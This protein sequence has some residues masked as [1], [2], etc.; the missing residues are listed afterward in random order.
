MKPDQQP[1]LLSDITKQGSITHLASAIT[2]IYFRDKNGWEDFLIW[3]DGHG[4][5]ASPRYPHDGNVL[6]RIA[7]AE[8]TRSTPNQA[9]R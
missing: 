6:V 4:F 5:T 9:P 8:P 3:A 1:Q 7:S 2:N